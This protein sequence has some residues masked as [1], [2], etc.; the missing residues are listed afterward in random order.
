MTQNSRPPRINLRLSIGLGLKQASSKS[1]HRTDHKRSTDLV[2]NTS[3]MLLQFPSLQTLDLKLELKRI[4]NRHIPNFVISLQ[5]A[6]LQKK[7]N[8][9]M[10]CQARPKTCAKYPKKYTT[11]CHG[12]A[13]II[14]GQTVTKICQEWGVQIGFNTGSEK[15]LTYFRLGQIYA[16]ENGLRQAENITEM[17][18]WMGSITVRNMPRIFHKKMQQ[19]NL[20]MPFHRGS[21]ILSNQP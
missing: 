10:L 14:L 4:L 21:N 17:R 18:L 16:A 2:S 8:T 13:K 19:I 6:L 5:V 11:K 9:M 1:N 7:N 20:E 3:N 12:S 15:T